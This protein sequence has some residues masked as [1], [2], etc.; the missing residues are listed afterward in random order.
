MDRILLGHGSG[1]R[2][3]HQLIREYFVPEFDM[4]SLGDSAVIDISDF[5]FWISDLKSRT[6][7]SKLKTQNLKQRLAFTTDSYVVSPIFFPGGNIGDLAVYG[8]VNDLAM[9]GAKPIY[10]SAGFIFEEG[11]LIDDFKKIL[12]TMSEAS[13]KAGVKI[14]AGDTKVVNK[15]KGDGIFINTSGIGIIEDGID[16][17]PGNIKTGDKIIVSGNIG[18]HGV[19]VMAERNGLSFN[20]PVLSDTAPLNHIVQE[21]LLNGEVHAMRDPTRGGVA[22]TLKEIALE[23]NLCLEIREDSIPIAQ[24][25][26]GASELLGLD[27][28]YIANEGILIA[29][30]GADVAVDLLNI[31]RKNP[32][33]ENANIIG[34]VKESPSGKVLLKTKIGGTRM[35]DM[36]SGE[37]LPRIC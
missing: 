15:G 12:R 16:I 28:L 8:T 29:I 17:S 11:F 19:A 30:V 20:P 13:K 33:G 22:T 4:K 5:G 25:V 24:G 26:R 9:V 1:G 27:P 23:S 3:M 7:N 36:L 18:N 10:L 34:K 21:M 31:I 35:L 6:Q 14:I 32:F 37:Q 2:L